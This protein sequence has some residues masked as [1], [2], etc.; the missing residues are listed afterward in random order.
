[1]VPGGEKDKRLNAE[2]AGRECVR[3]TE[4]LSGIDHRRQQDHGT[5]LVRGGERNGHDHEQ[6]GDA[7]DDLQRHRREQQIERQAHLARRRPTSG[8]PPESD[9]EGRPEIWP[10]STLTSAD[11]PRSTKSSRR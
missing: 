10:R 6:R 2:S 1:M 3:A 11:V 5:G 7:K 8:G 4:L 9:Y